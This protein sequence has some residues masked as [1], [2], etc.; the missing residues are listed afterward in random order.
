MRQPSRLL[1]PTKATVRFPKDMTRTTSG[2]L[3]SRR[4]EEVLM[5]KP[6]THF[7]QVPL[8]TVIKIVEEQIRQETITEADQETMQRTLEDLFGAQEQPMTRSLAFSRMEV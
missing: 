2:L 8:E 4:S 1:A 6:K 3:A 5:V 7:E